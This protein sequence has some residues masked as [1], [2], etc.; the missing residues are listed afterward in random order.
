MRKGRR[1]FS[2]HRAPIVAAALE[3]FRRRNAHLL[4]DFFNDFFHRPAVFSTCCKLKP[5]RRILLQCCFYKRRISDDPTS[6][7]LSIRY[8]SIAFSY[9]VNKIAGIGSTGPILHICAIF[10]NS[11]PRIMAKTPQN[12]P[13]ILKSAIPPAYQNRMPAPGKTI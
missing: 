6:E 13:N 10:L 9:N 5:L 3:N 11:N 4:R 8:F 2:K 12:S 1:Y 7:I